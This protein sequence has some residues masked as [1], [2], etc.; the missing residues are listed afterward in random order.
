MKNCAPMNSSRNFVSAQICYL[1]K[2]FIWRWV[3]V[4]QTLRRNDELKKNQLSKKFTKN[5]EVLTQKVT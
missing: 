1:G 5:P 3:H 4:T 2:E